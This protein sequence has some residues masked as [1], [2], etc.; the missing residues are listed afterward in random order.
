MLENERILLFTEIFLRSFIKSFGQ[1]E[2]K[3]SLS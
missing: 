2:N 3:N 1:F